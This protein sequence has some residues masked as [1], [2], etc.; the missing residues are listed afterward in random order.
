MK[1]VIA[2]LIL[3]LSINKIDAQN[4]LHDTI[5]IEAI[6]KAEKDSVT[7]ILDLIAFKDFEQIGFIN[8]YSSKLDLKASNGYC[9]MN[10][11]YLFD[12]ILSY[13]EKYQINGNDT[14]AIST[15]GRQNYQLYQKCVL[16]KKNKAII[17]KLTYKHI[18]YLQ[19][20]LK[21]WWSQN[22]QLGFKEI[23]LRWIK[24]APLKKIGYV[25]L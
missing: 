8:K 1:K 6:L 15:S 13:T 9:G 22:E 20:Y 10:Y 24:Q 12:L 17:T 4:I 18:S 25:W 2:L 3:S 16:V 23:K 7:K 14:S 21:K 19:K 5:R 11:L